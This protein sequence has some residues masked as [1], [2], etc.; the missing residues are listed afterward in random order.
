MDA[1]F[2]PSDIKSVLKFNNEWLS[3]VL[4]YSKCKLTVAGDKLVAI[5]SLAHRI[6]QKRHFKYLTGLWKEMLHYNLCWHI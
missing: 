3:L 6:L 2:D 1:E 4:E 5:S